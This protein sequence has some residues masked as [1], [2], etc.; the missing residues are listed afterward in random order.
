[1]VVFLC[2]CGTH[3]EHENYLIRIGNVLVFAISNSLSSKPYF[4]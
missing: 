2:T 3:V 4:R 1:M